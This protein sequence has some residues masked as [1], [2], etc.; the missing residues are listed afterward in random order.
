M[1]LLVSLS[2]V[3][4]AFW[5]KEGFINIITGVLLF[6][7]GLSYSNDYLVMGLMIMALGVYFWWITI[8]ALFGVKN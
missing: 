1:E 5:Q 3:I 4:V 7:T 6:F 2:F 8:A